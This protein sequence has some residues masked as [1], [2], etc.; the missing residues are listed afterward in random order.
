MRIL[1]RKSFKNRIE[2]YRLTTVSYDMASVPFLCN[3]NIHQLT[4]DEKKD[5]YFS[6][7]VVL[8]YF[9]VEEFLYGDRIRKK[10]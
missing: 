7:E 1:C 2:E 6:S 5:F 9:Y 3:R 4:V 10:P 8:R